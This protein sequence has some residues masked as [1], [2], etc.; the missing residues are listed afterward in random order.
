MGGKGGG[1]VNDLPKVGGSNWSPFGLGGTPGSL[2]KWDV[3]G[4]AFDKTNPWVQR[5]EASRN[6]KKESARI[7]D[8]LYNETGKINAGLDQADQAYKDSYDKGSRAYLDQ[9]KYLVDD[10]GRSLDALGQQAAG[11]ATDARQTY[12]NSILPAYKEAMQTAQKNASQAMTLAEAG[13]PN[14]PIMKG[15]RQLYNQQGES[16]R[17]QGQ[18]D[19]GVLSSLGAQAAQGQ[20]GASGPMTAGMMGQIYGANQAQAGDAYARAQQ[21]VYD[22][23]NQGLDKSFDQSNQIYQFGQQAQGRY[24]DTIKDLQ[25]GQSQQN[26]LLARLRDEQSGY[27]GDRLGAY[28]GLNTDTLNTNLLGSSIGKDV[29]YASGNRNQNAINQRSGV[30]QQGVNTE[31]QGQMANAGATT[32]LLSSLLGSVGTV[33]GAAAASDENEK[34]HIGKISDRDLD[35]F[36]TSVKP[37]TFEYKEPEKEGRAPG[38]RIGFMMQDVQ[39]TKLGDKMTRKG[40]E[41]ELMYDKDNLNGILLAG[42]A[43]QAKGKAA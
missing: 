31:L 21:R 29:A 9:A 24:S 15:I 35:E 39:G 11:Q 33:A 19:F 32:Q 16:V 43:R 27:S 25:G 12:S 42:L 14:N 17:K 6:A 40:P 41:G 10:Y 5:G 34:C 20:F 37:K 2:G 1:A 30:A 28:A 7:A 22:L 26:D 18:Q 36:L 23:Q 13:D 3:V 8:N 38:Q 4:N